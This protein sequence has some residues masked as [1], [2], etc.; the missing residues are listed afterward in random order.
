MVIAAT[1]ELFFYMQ[2]Y[3]GSFAQHP[4]AEWLA[5]LDKAIV[6]AEQLRKPNKPIAIVGDQHYMYI[7]PLFYEKVDPNEFRSTVQYYPNDALGLSQVKQFGNYVFISR[8]I[9]VPEGS[10]S[11]SQQSGGTIHVGK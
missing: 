11:I 10:I 8:G 1:L 2:I 5:G 6:Q 7:Y 3:L 9:D 4:Q